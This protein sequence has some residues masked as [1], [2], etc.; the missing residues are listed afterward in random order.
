VETARLFNSASH[1]AA[2]HKTAA[3]IRAETL[4]TAAGSVSS[5]V[6]LTAALLKITHGK[7]SHHFMHF[8]QESI[9]NQV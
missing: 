2:R 4:V 5:A 7:E 6:T 8:V 1:L 3:A 9:L